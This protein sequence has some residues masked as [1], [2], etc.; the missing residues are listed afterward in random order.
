MASEGLLDDTR[1]D[2]KSFS[3]GETCTP[4]YSATLLPCFVISRVYVPVG[5]RLN[6]KRPGLSLVVV[7]EIPVAIFVALTWT[8]ETT[9]LVEST[10]TPEMDPLESWAIDER[11]SSNTKIKINEALTYRIL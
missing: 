3:P 2:P 8:P 4:L 1:R 7:N 10:T 11:L 6:R 5:K 9:V